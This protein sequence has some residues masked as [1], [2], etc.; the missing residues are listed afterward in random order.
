MWLF[1]ERMM[2][3]ESFSDL[4][5]S[6]NSIVLGGMPASSRVSKYLSL[7]GKIT[8]PTKERGPGRFVCTE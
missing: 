2:K 4:P 5:D 8:P 3:S 1:S 7:E 6:K